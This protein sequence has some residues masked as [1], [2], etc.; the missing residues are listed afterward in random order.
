MSSK[1]KRVLRTRPEF[2]SAE[3]ILEDVQ[4]SEPSDPVFVPP[5][6]PPQDRDPAPG[7]PSAGTKRGT[8]GSPQPR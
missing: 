2:P 7:E 1:A 8:W 6:E 4:G 5:A 3:Q